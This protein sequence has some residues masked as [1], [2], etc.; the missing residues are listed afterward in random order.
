ML[1]SLFLQEDQEKTKTEKVYKFQDSW[2]HKR[3]WLKHD[4]SKLIMWCE[5]CRRF[6]TGKKKNSFRKG[7]KSLRLPNITSHEASPAHV[8]ACNKKDASML[9]VQNRPMPMAVQ[10]MEA[11][12]VDQMSTLFRSAYYL[13]KQ[14]RP[15][16][17]FPMLMKLQ[18]SNGLATVGKTYLNDKEA[19][20]FVDYIAQTIRSDM[21]THIQTSDFVSVLADGSTDRGAIEEEVV[22]VRY[23]RDNIVPTTAFVA[24]KPLERGDAEHVTSAVKS[25]LQDDLLM[26]GAWSQKLVFACFDGAPVNMGHISGVGVRLKEECP[27]LLVLACCAHRLELVFKDVLGEVQYFSTIHD[28]LS[29]LYKFYH[30]SPLNWQGLRN[31]AE[32][33]NIA[34]LKPVRAT[35]TRWLPHLER[36]VKAVCRDFR[37][38]VQHLGHLEEIGD[39][40]TKDSRDKAR[41]ILQVVK[42]VKF[43]MFLNFLVKYLELISAVSKVF[44]DNDS[45]IEV[46]FRRVNSVV[47]SLTKL[48]KPA[49]LNRILSDGLEERDGSFVWKETVL[50]T[51]RPQ[52]GR[53]RGGNHATYKEEVL[54]DCQRICDSTLHHLGRRFDVILSN[55]VYNSARVLFQFST[56]PTEE[57]DDDFGEENIRTLHHHFHAVLEQKDFDIDSC[58]RE[59]LELKSVCRA[60][61]AAMHQT[62]HFSTFWTSVLRRERDEDFKNIFTILRNKVVVGGWE[63][64]SIY[65]P[66][67]A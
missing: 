14:A 41:G 39:T 56:W 65:H 48:A 35:G 19:R 34:V 29:N 37:A 32:A 45:T 46:V 62:P 27:H 13:A 53:G 63:T 38:L 11:K 59:W 17:D 66:L 43:V 4:K 23:L 33:L 36:A 20:V 44:Q 61:L 22:H 3:P 49:K 50:T 40:G 54:Q 28:M 55:P 18:R 10:R 57:E 15:F 6:D 52:R 58:I 12:K 21:I 25:A 64:P 24:L 5:V 51:G 7:T 60:Q 67:W 47:S 2:K 26:E 30:Y 9:A 42:T 31:A 1:Q 8:T 16:S